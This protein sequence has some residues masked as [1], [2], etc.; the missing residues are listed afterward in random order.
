MVAG[1]GPANMIIL[2]A[3][4]KYG[5]KDSIRF[6]LG[7]ILSKQFII[8]P[9]GLGFL[10]IASYSPNT[11][12]VMKY[13]SAFYILWL[14]WKLFF[15][16][17]GNGVVLAPPRFLAGLVIH[18][19]NPKAWLMVTASFSSFGNFETSLF[20]QTAIVAAI[21]FVT[22]CIFHSI[23]LLLGSKISKLLHNNKLR[24]IFIFLLSF[25]TLLSVILIFT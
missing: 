16:E 12:L 21:F 24:R 15:A 6:L 2:A 17:L 13:F 14:A 4:L 9:V 22:Q 18:P 23:W 5:I 20:Y 10:S 7:I 1:P 3:G 11:Y 19:L 25:L 8:W